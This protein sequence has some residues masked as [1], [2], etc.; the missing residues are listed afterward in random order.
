MKALIIFGL[1]S[2]LALY[3]MFGT[4]HMPASVTV[5]ETS[6][7]VNGPALDPQLKICC[8]KL[9][10]RFN[11]VSGQKSGQLSK[12]NKTVSLDSSPDVSEMITYIVKRPAN[13]DNLDGRFWNQIFAKNTGYL[14]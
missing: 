9:P 14:H 8:Q 7:K 6:H 13:H 4:R 5:Q 2:M 12:A 1:S 11:M 10:G 3:G